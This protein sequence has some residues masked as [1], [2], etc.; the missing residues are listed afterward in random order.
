MSF[1][2]AVFLSLALC[3]AQVLAIADSAKFKL[4]K[5]VNLSRLEYGSFAFGHVSADYLYKESTYTGLKA[6]GFDHIRLP[7]DFRNYYDRSSNALKSNIADIDSILDLCEL[8]QL[9]VCV[10]FHGWT[11]IN[12]DNATDKADFLNIWELVADRYKNRSDYVVFELI[13][14]PHTTDGGNLDVAKLNELQAEVL[15]LIRRTNPS[16]LVLLAAAD[17]NGS[18]KL[19]EL[20]IPANAGPIGVAVHSYSPLDFTHQSYGQETVRFSSSDSTETGTKEID[21]AFRWIDDF[22]EKTGIPVVVNEFGVCRTWNSVVVEDIYDWTSYM[23]G[24]CNRSGTAWTWWEYN[25]GFGLYRQNK[26]D[27]TVMSA[28]FPAEPAGSTYASS[29]KESDYAKKLTISF[30]GYAGSS[31]LANFP[32]LVKL[33]TSIS[34]FKYSDFK[35]ANGDD[36]RFTDSDGN[37]VPH[38]VDTWNTNGVSTVWVRIPSLTSATTIKAHYG[39]TLP[40]AVDSSR[41]WD[42]GYVGVWHLGEKEVPLKE[43]SLESTDFTIA[44]GDGI[45]YAQAGAVGGSVDFGKSGNGRM[46]SALD[47]DALDGFTNCTVEA[48]TYQTSNT[49]AAILSKRYSSSKNVSYFLYANGTKTQVKFAKSDSTADGTAQVEPAL[50][51]WTHQAYTFASGIVKGY[52]NGSKVGSD[53]TLSFTKIANSDGYLHLGNFNCDGWWGVDQRNF[54]GKIDEVRISNV[55]RSADWL[56]ASHDTVT[57][58]DFATYAVDGVAPV[59]PESA[60][61]YGQ[62][63]MS[64][65][66]K[67]MTVTFSGAQSGTTLTDFPV[68]VKLSTAI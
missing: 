44:H 3:S 30:P 38:E 32:V 14:E 68:L 12:T 17:W 34:G 1:K 11:N 42:N 60:I 39:C 64:G 28:L 27:E 22:Q 47:C 53:K 6:K 50:N 41:V 45:K 8:H 51:Q 62:L 19:S 9:Y 52:K 4:K 63:D 40:V 26:W 7:V 23:I 61:E 57:Q 31:A 67:K 58:A 43:S 20:E 16:R 29:F 33:S 21:S 46:I 5:G 56:Q 66:A 24:H 2:T 36:L 25:D 49:T 54:P 37:L 15:P 55:A 18:W 65:F 48:W 10:D 35:R 59:E 13:N